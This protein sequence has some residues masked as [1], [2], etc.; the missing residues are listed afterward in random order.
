[1]PKGLLRVNG[2]L[3]ISQFWP[4]GGSDADTVVVQ[5][6]ANSFEFSPE[7]AKT[8]FKTTHVFEGA[9]KGNKK[10]CDPRRQNN[11]TPAGY[12]CYGTSFFGVAAW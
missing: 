11:H 2:N 1:M 3:D 12:R 8:P 10:T 9:I 6:K 4:R 7:P 5:V